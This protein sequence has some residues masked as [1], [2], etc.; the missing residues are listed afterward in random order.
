MIELPLPD[1]IPISIPQTISELIEDA[2]HRREFIL[3]EH[4]SP[5]LG[6]VPGDFHLI[7]QGLSYLK[8]K[9]SP[10]D[11]FCEWGCGIGVVVALAERLGFEA[12]GIEIQDYLIEEGRSFFESKSISAELYK[13]S[14]IP[15]DFEASDLVDISERVTILDGANAIDEVEHSID[16]FDLIYAFPWPGEEEL[17]F[18]LF[19]ERAQPGS[20]LLTYHGP[21]EGLLLQQKGIND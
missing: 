11:Q 17:Y 6:Y 21:T 5:L 7:Y 3:N 8:D 1:P 9:Y 4:R 2:H 12:H 15:E 13:G 14:F 19:E 10:G 20:L 16:E 18:N